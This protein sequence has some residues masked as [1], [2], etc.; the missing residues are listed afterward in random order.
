MAQ[1]AYLFDGETAIEWQVTVSP[2]HDAILIKRVDGTTDSV[3]LSRLVRVYSAPGRT[4]L[5]RR[6]L[7]GWRLLFHD[8]V[9]PEIAALLPTRRSSLTPPISRKAAAIGALAA[10]TVVG[11]TASVFVAP[12]LAAS[13]MP[14]ALERKI[15]DSVKFAEY[16]PRCENP[17]ALAALN[18]IVDRLDPEARPDGFTIEILDVGTV[19]AAALPGGR[20]VVLNGLIDAAET[21]DVLAGVIAHEIAHVRRRHV[22]SAAVRQLGVASV[23]SVIG[24]GDLSAGAA[25]LLALKFDRDAESEADAD[26]IAMLERA[27]INPGPTAYMFERMAKAEH[28]TTEWLASHPA[29]GDRA[30]AF[31]ASRQDGLAYRPALTAGEEDALFESCRWPYLK[32]DGGNG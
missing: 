2:S 7:A 1:Q 10:A 29:S 22:A 4:R 24:G 18:K 8:A 32:Y 27:G 9:D 20:I 31:A 13:Q 6:D 28:G 17:Q 14:L 30:K 5:G 23:V 19:N 25:G 21:G 12:H 11:L 16:V 3:P 15:G 26:A